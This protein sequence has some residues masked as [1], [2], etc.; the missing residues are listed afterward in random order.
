MAMGLKYAGTGNKN[1]SNTIIKL[2]NKF[3]N[4]K[5]HSNDLICDNE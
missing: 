5:Y 4:M 2:I 1:A 3:R